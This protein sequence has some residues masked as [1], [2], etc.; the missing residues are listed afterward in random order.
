MP[1][2]NTTCE[3]A[4]AGH[5]QILGRE[6]NCIQRKVTLV[7]IRPIAATRRFTLLAAVALT[8]VVAL[9]NAAQAAPASGAIMWMRADVGVTVNINKI[10]TW[11]DQSGFG[12]NGTMTVVGR[13]P[14]LV[15]GAL[16]GLPVIHFGGAQSL[17]IASPPSPQNFT[18]FIV[19]RNSNP[20][21]TP[22]MIMGPTGNFPN[23]QIRWENG[24]QAL[25]VGTGNNL[26]VVTSPIGNTRT[27]HALSVRY[28]GSSMRVYRDGGLV[29]TSFF[30]TTG[31]FTL[32]SIGSYYAQAFMTGDLAEILIY[33]Q[34]LSDTD[35]ATTNSY[36]STKYGLP[37]GASVLTQVGSGLSNTACN[38]WGASG[39]A[40][41]QW[42]TWWCS[43]IVVDNPNGYALYA[44]VIQ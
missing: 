14:D 30:T 39:A 11:A 3:F 7:K 15:L 31:P 13:Q 42:T 41:G 36:L 32:A 37:R 9:P 34:A 40:A 29:S 12:H 1:V 18:I 21:E 35:R 28:D 22:S 6:F 25:F 8:T 33:P 27:Y 5:A 38:T 2:Y 17:N 4:T 44:Y 16:N 19:G 24:S 43:Q 26:P 20:T 10:T 23:N